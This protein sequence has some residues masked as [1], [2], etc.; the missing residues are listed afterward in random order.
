MSKETMLTFG[1]EL[2]LNAYQLFA[3]SRHYRVRYSIVIL[4]LASNYCNVQYK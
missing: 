3:V 4:K 2:P 1:R